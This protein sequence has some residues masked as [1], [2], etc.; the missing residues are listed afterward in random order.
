MR[1]QIIDADALEYYKKGKTIIQC[2]SADLE[3][4]PNSL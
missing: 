1:A 3:V 4:V 2:V